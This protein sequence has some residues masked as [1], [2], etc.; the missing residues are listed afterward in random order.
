L[1]RQTTHGNAIILGFAV[2]RFRQN[3]VK[4]Y[5]GLDR[6]RI[7]EPLPA[8]YG[9]CAPVIELPSNRNWFNADR[10]LMPMSKQSPF[11]LRKPF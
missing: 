2:E 5:A 1:Q 6:F 9:L 8:V 3:A 10:R 4:Q 7:N 11:E